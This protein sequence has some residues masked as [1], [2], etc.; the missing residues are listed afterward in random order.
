M[1]TVRVT[2]TDDFLN[3]TSFCADIGIV[4]PLRAVWV[5]TICSKQ[6]SWIFLG[7]GAETILRS[8]TSFTSYT[9]TANVMGF[10]TTQLTGYNAVFTGLDK[11]FY[12]QSVY[13]AALNITTRTDLQYLE[14]TLKIQTIAVKRH[15]ES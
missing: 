15:L 6:Q 2:I 8:K 13:S 1:V 10:K 5:I 11:S 7:T 14:S 3:A 12:S 9:A 4:R